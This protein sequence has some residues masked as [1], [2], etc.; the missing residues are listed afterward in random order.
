MYKVKEN[1]DYIESFLEKCRENAKAIA[2]RRGSN[3]SIKTVFTIGSTK[4]Y[5]TKLL[6][7]TTPTRFNKYFY[8]T[9]CVVFTQTQAVLVARMIDGLVDIVLVDAEKKLPILTSPDTELLPKDI[10]KEIERLKKTVEISE[11]GNLSSA[12]FDYIKKSLF[13]EFKANDLTVEAVWAFLSDKIKVL[14]GKKISVIGAGNIGAKLALKLVEC[15]AMVNICRRN[16]YKGYTIANAINLIKPESTIASVSYSNDM[17]KSCFLTDV[18]LGCTDGKPVLEWEHICV[19][20]KDSIII[21]VGKGSIS[22]DAVKK[23]TET[24]KIIYRADVTAALDALLM[25]LIRNKEI[26]ESAGR[27]RISG[28][29]VISGGIYGKKGEAVIDNIITPS[30]VMGIADGEGDLMLKPGAEEK[31][32]L[33]KLESAISKKRNR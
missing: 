4:N 2:G 27:T 10:L 11:A 3:K 28:M 15:G 1:K 31:K 5:K 16:E 32:V 12:C 33:K 17:L 22:K 14:S 21:D 7:Y 8:I 23:A 19:S 13:Y 30:V 25:L 6:P 29:N 26:T 18:I 9:G 24:G 20:K